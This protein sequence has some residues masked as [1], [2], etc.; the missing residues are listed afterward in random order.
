MMWQEMDLE[1]SELAGR[2]QLAAWAVG[3]GVYI[4]G[5][6]G[7]LAGWWYQAVHLETSLDL[8]MLG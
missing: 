6:L 3:S 4:P 5:R 1:R 7:M 2:S 8:S